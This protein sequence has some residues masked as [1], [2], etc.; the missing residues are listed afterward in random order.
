[1]CNDKTLALIFNIVKDFALVH[2]LNISLYVKHFPSSS[3]VHV[4]V[5]FSFPFCRKELNALSLEQVYSLK[6]PT[7]G[8]DFMS[9]P[10]LA[11]VHTPLKRF[12]MY[13]DRFCNVLCSIHL[14]SFIFY[15]ICSLH[16]LCFYINNAKSVLCRDLTQGCSIIM[17]QVNNHQFPNYME[18]R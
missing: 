10:H 17:N 3:G 8:M 9:N 1:M 14:D 4:V 13:I 18:T 11:I 12:T 6:P 2:V 16:S 5:N 15:M 7:Q